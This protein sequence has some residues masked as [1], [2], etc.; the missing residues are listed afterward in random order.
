MKYI[1]ILFFLLSFTSWSQKHLIP[2]SEELD[3]SFSW[4]LFSKGNVPGGNHAIT[5]VKLLLQI[6]PHQDKRMTVQ[7]KVLMNTLKS[8]Y[9]KNIYKDKLP[10]QSLLQHEKLHFDINE[11]HKRLFFERLSKLKINDM[12]R[13]ME[14]IKKEY[15][16]TMQAI[17]NMQNKYDAE[18]NFSIDKEAQ[19]KWQ[20][21][22]TKKIK[23]LKQFAGTE[24]IVSVE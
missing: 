21:K 7:L 2:W 12:D 18:T 4:E 22:I 3:K 20:K 14:R 5:S 24:I 17:Q 10:S 15:Q 8:H 16:K 19:T 1:S 6:I 11:Y 23:Q 9:A 13:L